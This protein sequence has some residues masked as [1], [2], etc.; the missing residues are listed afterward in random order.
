MHWNWSLIS[1][2]RSLTA[3]IILETQEPQVNLHF[4]NAVFQWGNRVLWTLFIY[5][6]L[7]IKSFVGEEKDFKFC[8]LQ[9]ASALNLRMEKYDLFS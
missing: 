8:T 7:S 3:P 6:G 4:G 9:G 5:D 2:Q 1:Q